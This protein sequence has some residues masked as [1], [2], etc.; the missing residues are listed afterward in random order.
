MIEDVR[1]ASRHAIMD[2][3]ALRASN[4]PESLEAGFF[5]GVSCFLGAS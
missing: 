5:A 2:H 1:F 3:K 4:G